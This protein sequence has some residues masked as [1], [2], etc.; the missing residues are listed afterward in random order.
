MTDFCCVT[1]PRD[2]AS[3][4]L[5]SL[6]SYEWT[7]SCTSYTLLNAPMP[8]GKTISTGFCQSTWK[9]SQKSNR[10]PSFFVFVAFPSEMQKHLSLVLTNYLEP[11]RPLSLKVF[12]PQKTRPTFQPKQLKNLVPSLKKRNC[13][14]LTWDVFKKPCK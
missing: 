3:D 14:K 2:T 6:F 8:C 9:I 5:K 12:P 11:Q 7:K 10:L 4:S 1:L 13:K